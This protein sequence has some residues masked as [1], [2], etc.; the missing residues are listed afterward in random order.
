MALVVGTN[1][2]VTVAEAVAYL[3]DR[4]DTDMWD[5]ATPEDQAKAL[6]TATRMIDDKAFV[7]QMVSNTQPLC[8]PRV[9]ATIKDPKFGG[10]VTFPTTTVPERLKRAVIEQ[11]LHLLSNE[12]L[13]ESRALELEKIK[14]GPIEI[15]GSAANYKA[16]PKESPMVRELI[17]PLLAPAVSSNAVWRAW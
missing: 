15:E 6:V 11:A 17:E 4:I 2:Y 1:S 13:L 12:N 3:A 7:G 10:T 8:W 16:P 9:N 14:V 5:T